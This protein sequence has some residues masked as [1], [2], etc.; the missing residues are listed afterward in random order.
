MEDKANHSYR[1][2]AINTKARLQ[3]IGAKSPNL[4]ACW[5]L[6]TDARTTFYYASEEKLRRHISALMADGYNEEQ[7]KVIKPRI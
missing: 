1:E 4:N 5:A 3:S 6:R 2:R 7:F